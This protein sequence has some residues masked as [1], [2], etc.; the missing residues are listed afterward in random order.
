[1]SLIANVLWPKE[2]FYS[3]AKSITQCIMDIKLQNT[4]N[5]YMK[6]QF[7]SADNWNSIDLLRNL[8]HHWIFTLRLPTTQTPFVLWTIRCLSLIEWNYFRKIF[9]PYFIDEQPVWCCTWPFSETPTR[10][11]P[12]VNPTLIFVSKQK[13]VIEPKLMALSSRSSLKT[14]DVIFAQYLFISEAFIIPLRPLNSWK[15]EFANFKHYENFL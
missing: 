2:M 15:W 1:M 11:E 9:V 3:I 8:M 14:A 5:Y 4:L 6:V 7:P 12:L 10:L 13:R